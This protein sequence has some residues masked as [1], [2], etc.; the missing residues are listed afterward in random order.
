MHGHKSVVRAEAMAHDECLP[1]DRRLAVTHDAE[2]A[3]AAAE[4]VRRIAH[5]RPGSPGSGYHRLSRDQHRWTFDDPIAPTFLCKAAFRPD[6][7]V[8]YLVDEPG[9][10]QLDARRMLRRVMRPRTVVVDPDMLRG[11]HPDHFELVNDIPRTADDLVRPDAEL[12]QAEAEAY[13]RER[14][15]DLLIEADFTS[16]AD[17]AL[18]AG[19]FARAGYRIEAVTLAPAV[20]LAARSCDSRQRTLVNHARALELDVVT[21]LSTPAALAR[22]CRVAA[23]IVAAAA[24]DPSISAVRVIDGDRWALGRDRWAACA[25]AAA[26]R[27]PYTDGEAAGFHSVPRALHRVL[28]RLRQEIA[29]IMARA[30]PLMPAAWQAVPMEYQR[31]PGRPP[32]LRARRRVARAQDSKTQVGNGVAGVVRE[33]CASGRGQTNGV[34]TRRGSALGGLVGCV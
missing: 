1:A 9:A 14:S 33:W 31:V 20:A 16:A 19:R 27:R 23:D 12:W 10:R 8:V 22:A 18:S 24:A 30:Q 26:R 25:L 6:P 17:F 21:A 28:P 32:L 13:V 2:R 11:H 5:P 7:L 29:G 34:R 15:R 3:A 4:P